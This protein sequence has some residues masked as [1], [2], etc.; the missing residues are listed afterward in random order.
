MEKRSAY[1]RLWPTGVLCDGRE[2]LAKY[3][4]SARL[5]DIGGSAMLKRVRHILFAVRCAHD[6]H[7]NIFQRRVVLENLQHLPAIALRQ[8]KVEQNQIGNR[9]FRGIGER[10]F[11]EQVI[12][13]LLPVAH[14]MNGSREIIA[15]E[16]IFSE[17][18]VCEII[19]DD[20]DID[21]LVLHEYN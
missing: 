2:L 8:I 9:E 13:R 1:S 15:A 11:P 16:D 20:E 7:G 6:D 4:E 5:A 14:N 3:F 10:R 21:G 18:E 12:N 17:L 19:F